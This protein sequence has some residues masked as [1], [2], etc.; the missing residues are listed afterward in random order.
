MTLK[1]KVTQLLY[2]KY[3]FVEGS[4]YLAPDTNMGFAIENFENG[5]CFNEDL[6]NKSD[7][8]AAFIRTIKGVGECKVTELTEDPCGRVR[9]SITEKSSEDDAVTHQQML[10]KF[11]QSDLPKIMDN[12]KDYRCYK[13][14][15]KE[16]FTIRIVP[17][18]EPITDDQIEKM[19]TKAKMFDGKV[20]HQGN[21]VWITTD[22]TKPVGDC[23]KV[24]DAK[25]MSKIDKEDVDFLIEDEEEAIDGY[26]EVL[27]RVKDKEQVKVLKSII[28][29]EKRHIKMIKALLK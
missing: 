4:D 2:D 21:E 28:A 19:Q 20:E 8:I 24:T 23:A 9:Y 6:F 3:G 10:I 11:I 5:G 27:T 15:D 29:D 16:T 14:Q 17:E 1:S 12:R 13:R 18:T 25:P 7:E 26:N 22:A